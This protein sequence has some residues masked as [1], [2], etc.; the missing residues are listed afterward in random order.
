[1][2]LPIYN[3]TFDPDLF[4]SGINMIAITETPAIQVKAL[5]FNKD[6]AP[7][8]LAFNADKR[9][10]IGPA[11][12]PNKP[13]YRNEGG[14]EFFVIFQQDTIDQML[15]KFNSEVREVQFNL[16]HD[17]NKPVKAFVKEAWIVEDSEKDKSSLYG[18]NLPVGTLMIAAK[19]EDHDIW[20][21]VIKEKEQ[22]GFSIEGLMGISTIKQE[23]EDEINKN[24][25]SVMAQKKKFFATG[26]KTVKRFNKTLKKFETEL[27]SSEN[28]V[29]IVEALEVDQPATMVDANGEVVPV[30]DGLYEIPT[31]SVIIEVVDGIIT[32]VNDM[33]EGVQETEET[34]TVEETEMVEDVEET[35]TV[36]ETEE[37]E[38][39]EMPD[40]LAEKIASLESRL[41][42][43]E[44]I[45]AGKEAD[46]EA[47][48][49]EF[50]NHTGDRLTSIKEFLNK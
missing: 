5:R 9:L 39:T 12:I 26:F 23:F 40:E 19:I 50:T 16:E 8:E 29:I 44:A 6:D 45:L 21:K 32:E 35:E 36:E 49:V 46:D 13:L 47:A 20:N 3:I 1:M 43:I 14:R 41:E 37:V 33:V 28:E 38:E 25:T 11:I 22:I 17:I 10:I 48:H 30:I 15:E 4:E 31:E 34:E 7:M 24:N 2:E 42:A 18:F 27:V